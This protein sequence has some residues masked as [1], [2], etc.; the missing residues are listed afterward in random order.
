[1]S[2][3]PYGPGGVLSDFGGGGEG[4]VPKVYSRRDPLKGPRTSEMDP[5]W[6]T[7]LPLIGLSPFPGPLTRLGAS[8]ELRSQIEAI[9][10]ADF[11]LP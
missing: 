8:R 3:G 7:Q 11:D 9:S 4:G 5:K 1:M 6:S 10:G 2:G